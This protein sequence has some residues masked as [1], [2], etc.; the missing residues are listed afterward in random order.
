MKIMSEETIARV[1]HD[2]KVISRVRANDKIVTDGGYLNLDHG[3]ILSPFYR[4]ANNEN[5][6][7]GLASVSNIISDAFAISENGFRKISSIEIQNAKNRDLERLKAYH[8]VTK[9]RCAIADSLQGLKHM[10]ATYYKDTSITAKLDVLEQ[11]AIQGLK[12]MDCS[13]RSLRQELDVADIEET[14][15]YKNN[16]DLQPR[17]T[18]CIVLDTDRFHETSLVS[19]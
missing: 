10:R 6:T 7:K 14:E 13:I 9:L 15:K 4:W 19:R 18:E 11:G 16:L 2:L 5:R 1:L 17:F 8:L 12:E 3:G